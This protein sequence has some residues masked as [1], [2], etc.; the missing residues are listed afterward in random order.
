MNRK[1]KYGVGA[2]LA[3]I[4]LAIIAP[5]A[6]TQSNP[7]P[8]YHS[9]GLTI[10]PGNGY[11]DTPAVI[12]PG[13]M[14][15]VSPDVDPYGY[16]DYT[17]DYNYPANPY[18]VSFGSNDIPR[19]SDKIT[20]RKESNNRLYMQWQGE[21]RAVRNIT[22]AVLDSN[23]KVIRQQT[24]SALPAEARLTRSTKTTAYSV[25]IN[26]IN[27]TSTSIVSPL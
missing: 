1:F 11:G 10:V 13:G 14:Q 16:Y 2:A 24:I 27:G 4:S 6:K 25:T 3:V 15:R 22:F 21:P 9:G 12:G 20:A 5:K 23:N 17:G 18:N 19:T 8:V 7:P 26:Y